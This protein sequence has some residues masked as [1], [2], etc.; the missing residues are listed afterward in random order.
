MRSPSRGRLETDIRSGFSSRGRASVEP[1]ARRSLPLPL[2][3][4]R[5]REEREGGKRPCVG[6][7]ARAWVRGCVGGRA[8][9]PRSHMGTHCW[10]VLKNNRAGER[11]AALVVDLVLSLVLKA[12]EPAAFPSGWTTDPAVTT[13]QCLQTGDLVEMMMMM[14]II[15][16]S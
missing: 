2:P 1:S 12:K 9:T 3:P 16:H 10:S 11:K 13:L 15:K 7:R 5:H 14:M 4:F 6:A 8:P